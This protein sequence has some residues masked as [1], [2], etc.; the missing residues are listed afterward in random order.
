[1]AIDRQAVHWIWA[2]WVL[3]DEDNMLDRTDDVNHR[4]VVSG[5]SRL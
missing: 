2:G 1:M 5:F 3:K 4:V